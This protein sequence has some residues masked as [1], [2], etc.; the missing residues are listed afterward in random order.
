MLWLNSG[1]WTADETARGEESATATQSDR[2]T[3]ERSVDEPPHPTGLTFIDL[4]S[5]SAVA[6]MHGLGLGAIGE[7]CL[8]FEARLKLALPLILFLFLFFFDVVEEHGADMQNKVTE[9][10]NKRGEK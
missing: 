10:R 4:L 1:L 8:S 9:D 3:D 6:D 5:V 7:N 2:R